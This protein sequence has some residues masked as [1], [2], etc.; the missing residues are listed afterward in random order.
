MASS[1]LCSASDIRPLPSTLKTKLSLSQELPGLDD[2]GDVVFR[3]RGAA[4]LE[5]AIDRD[6]H[7]QIALHVG[8]E[9]ARLD[10]GAISGQ[11]KPLACRDN[12]RVLRRK[13]QATL[14]AG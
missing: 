13:L 3:L 2:V 1:I 14:D 5:L 4:G 11:A 9:A 8:R 6:C 12:Q 10:E 7:C